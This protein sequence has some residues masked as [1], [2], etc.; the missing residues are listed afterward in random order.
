MDNE[1]I[2]GIIAAANHANGNNQLTQRRCLRITC[3][4][5]LNR[6]PNTQALYQRYQRKS[7]NDREEL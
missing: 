5:W 2:Q 4:E 6:T 3:V 7:Q 1:Q